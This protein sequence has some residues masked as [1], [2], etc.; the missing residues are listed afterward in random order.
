MQTLTNTI[1]FI[2]GLITVVLTLF[3]ALSTFVLP[4][5]AICAIKQTLRSHK[6]CGDF[7]YRRKPSAMI[8]RIDAKI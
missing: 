5:A 7:V 4:R 6:D 3:S 8:Q 2:A 1:A